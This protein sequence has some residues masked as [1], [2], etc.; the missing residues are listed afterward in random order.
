MG[1]PLVSVIVTTYNREGFLKES[2]S[3]ILAQTF[4]DFELIVVDNYSKY[5]FFKV[6][7]EFDDPRI[8]PFQ[9][10][11]NGIIAV[12]RNFGI[13]KASGKFLAF[14]DDDDL[15]MPDKLKFQMDILTKYGDLGIVCTNIARFSCD[16]KNVILKKGRDK[17]VSLNSLLRKNPIA[18][19]YLIK[20][21]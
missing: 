8:R 1:E 2:I 9:N 6:I 19:S 17:N 13:S 14:C 10:A 16:V 4:T 21:S 15:W 3:S 5:D 7:G 18:T 12:N 11:N 20:T